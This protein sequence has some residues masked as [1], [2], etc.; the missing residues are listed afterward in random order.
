VG[1]PP[2]QAREGCALMAPRWHPTPPD[3][4]IRAE[5]LVGDGWVPCNYQDLRKGDV[6]RSRDPDGNL[7][8]QV[9]LED[10]ENAVA[11]AVDDPIKN[12][13]LGSTGQWYGY[14]VSCEIFASLDDLK[15][16][17]N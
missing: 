15:R 17:S 9:T 1:A 7:I 16:G 10:D 8:N 11:I 14:G 4:V 5:R 6:F 3:E 13:P 2:G 12:D